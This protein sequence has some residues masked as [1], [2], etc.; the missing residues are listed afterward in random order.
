MVNS[1]PATGKGEIRK[2]R[3]VW[4][5]TPGDPANGHP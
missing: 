5:V 4:N 2:K 3:G 1:P